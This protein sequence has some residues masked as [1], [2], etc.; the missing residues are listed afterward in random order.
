MQGIICKDSRNEVY[1]PE[2][3]GITGISLK[4]FPAEEIAEY[5]IPG[6]VLKINGISGLPLVNLFYAYI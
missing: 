2:K 3:A 1:S 4:V 5:G 6:G